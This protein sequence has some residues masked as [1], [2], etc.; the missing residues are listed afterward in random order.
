MTP[1]TAAMLCGA[2]FGLGIWLVIRSRLRTE[3]H[4]G[5]AL[6]QLRPVERVRHQAAPRDLT[7]RAGAWATARLSPGW[8]GRVA[9]EDLAI[10]EIDPIRHAGE[11]TLGAVFGLLAPALLCSGFAAIGVALPSWVPVIAGLVFAT[12]LFL[13]PD[14]TAARSAAAERV[15]FARAL[16]AYMD[17]VSLERTAAAGVTEAMESAARITSTPVFL[18]LRETLGNARLSGQPPWDGLA[19]LGARVGVTELVDIANIMRLAGE[20]SSASAA[21]LKARAS[22]I[23]NT[24]AEDAHAQ[25]NAA[26]ERMIVPLALL[27][28]VYLSI[29]AAPGF[30]R[31]VFGI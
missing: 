5:D 6:A 14:L 22:A 18:R 15:E 16:A 28:F 13:S 23:R 17:L 11:K 30:L 21:T 2:G 27:A 25:A 29:L 8:F 3:P 7:T 4:L 26:G 12:A 24:L 19:G 20:Q 1:A 9:S 31:V 10:L